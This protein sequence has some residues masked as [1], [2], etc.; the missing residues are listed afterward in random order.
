MRHAE[1]SVEVSHQK[2]NIQVSPAI[3]RKSKIPTLHSISFLGPD[4]RR[5]KG[6]L[7]MVALK[8]GIHADYRCGHPKWSRNNF[9]NNYL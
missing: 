7:G 4:G 9:G 2:S 1:M 3:H 8:W 5:G 6:G